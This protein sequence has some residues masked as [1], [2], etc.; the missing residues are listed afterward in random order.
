MNAMSAGLVQADV[1]AWV[2]N[3]P[4]ALILGRVDANAQVVGDKTD[5]GVNWASISNQGTIVTLTGTMI[6]TVNN[7]VPLLWSSITSTV[8]PQNLTGTQIA[9]INNPA[10]INWASVTNP[11]TGL[12]L[13][14]TVIGTTTD[15]GQTAA[16]HIIDTNLALGGRGNTRNVQNAL[17]LL[18][19]DRS[20]IF[21]AMNTATLTVTQ[22]DDST[23]AWTAIIST[24]S[25]IG[26]TEINPT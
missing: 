6:A 26:L 15:V 16:D 24:G 5:Y 8:A 13:S 7:P 22:E 18:R 2:A 17:R 10:P 12:T 9:S 23:T 4:N 19:N 21:G 20:L 1:R 14:G 25:T 11:T 3:L